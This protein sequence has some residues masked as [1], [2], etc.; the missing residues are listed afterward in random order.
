MF[1]AHVMELTSDGVVGGIKE[2]AEAALPGGDVCVR[3]EY[4]S[5]NYKDALALKGLGKIVRSYPA[6][7]GIDFAGTVMASIDNAWKAGDRVVVFGLPI[8]RQHW[9]GYAQLANV[10]GDRVVGLSDAMS[11]HNAMALGTAGFTAMLSVMALEEHGVKPGSGPVIVTGAGGGVGGFAIAL[12]AKLGYEVAA[13]TGRLELSGYLMELGATRIVPRGQMSEVSVKPLEGG[14][15]A[16][17]ID[18]VGSTVLARVL[19]QMKEGGS[20]VT[21]GLAG[22]SD[23]QTTM[24]PFIL[25]GVNLLGIDSVSC[26]R[27]RRVEAWGRLEGLIEDRHLKLIAQDAGLGDLEAMADE[28]LAGRVR[29]R[30]VIDVNG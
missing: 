9:G 3:V 8:D 27:G 22:G 6:V 2:M 5:L 14:R 17:C 18:S 21:V 15:W 26:E 7:A 19:G 10:S 23:L 20:A 13:V 12:L 25:R 1:L 30:V 29:G 11:T 24:M 28:L 16:G 4:A